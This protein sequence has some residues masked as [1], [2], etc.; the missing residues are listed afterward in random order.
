M[1]RVA[2][3]VKNLTKEINGKNRL[4]AISFNTHAS[5]IVALVGPKGSGVSLIT[6]ILIGLVNPNSGNI[7]YFDHDLTK[8]RDYIMNFVGYKIGEF[9][10]W[11]NMTIKKYLRYSAS[12]YEGDYYLKALELASYFNLSLNAKLKDLNKE[13]LQKLAIVDAIFFEPEV[14]ILDKLFTDLSADTATLVKNLLNTLKQKGCS[15][16]FTTD[17]LNDA[18]FADKLFLL[19]DGAILNVQD[20]T[21]INKIY[22][23]VRIKTKYILDK[24][25]F[26]KNYKNLTIDGNAATFTYLGEMGELL[27]FISSLNVVDLQITNPCLEELYQVV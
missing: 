6:K 9:N 18:N 11:K 7:T 13:G 24:E 12:F 20:S 15:I 14:I 22:K 19:K 10:P 8:E 5:E 4:N 3:N 16:L 21:I 23:Q 25:Q 26:N 17:N 2:I 1:E 27:K